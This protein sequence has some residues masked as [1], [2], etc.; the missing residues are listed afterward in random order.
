M[1]AVTGYYHCRKS[2]TVNVWRLGARNAG[3]IPVQEVV[4]RSLLYLWY[5]IQNMWRLGARNA[6]IIPVQEVVSQSL[7][8]VWYNIQNMWRLGARNAGIIP[9]QEVVGLSSTCGTI[10]RICGG[11]VPGMRG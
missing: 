6:G 9:V 7:L 10:Y 1:V 2:S 8:Y 5:N 4:S 3:I 11:W